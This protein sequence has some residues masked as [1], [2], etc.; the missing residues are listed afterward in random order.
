M[1]VDE[2]VAVAGGGGPGGIVEGLGEVDIVEVELVAALDDDR[3]VDL[4]CKIKPTIIYNPYK[5]SKWQKPRSIGGLRLC[6]MSNIIARV[7]HVF[8]T[9]KICCFM[10]DI[11]IKTAKTHQMDD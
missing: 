7:Y 9:E 6:F 5:K 4:K 1:V 10:E 8:F 2:E 11:C 3:L